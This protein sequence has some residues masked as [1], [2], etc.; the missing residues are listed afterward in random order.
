[1]NK[2][3]KQ[4]A[5][6]FEITGKD[7]E[8]YDKVSPIFGG[9]KYQIPPPTLCPSCRIQ[10]RHAWRNE[11]NLNKRKCDLCNR[12]IVSIYEADAAFPVF[13]NDC[14]WS[15]K[16]DA[17]EYGIDFEY[18]K[19]FFDQFKELQMKVPK[20]AILNNTVENSE[21]TNHSSNLKN[22]YLVTTAVYSEN[23]YHSRWLLKC[24]DVCDCYQ[25][26]HC[27]LCYE[28][29]YTDGGYNN[30]HAIFSDSQDCKFTYDCKG[31]SNCFMCSNLRQKK[32]CINNKQY[33]K[34]EY[35]KKMSTI[36]LGSYKEFTKYKSQY[37]DMIADTAIRQNVKISMSENSDYELIY[38]CKNVHNS[39]G[40][41][42][43][44][45]CSYCHENINSK[46]CY[47]VCE[48]ANCELHYETNGCDFSNN[49]MVCNRSDN[50]SDSLYLDSCYSGSNLFGCIGLKREKYCILNKQYSQ[51][52]YQKVAAKIA[53]HMSSTGEWG[54]FFP[55]ALS[56][57]AYNV[58][59]VNEDFPQ[60]KEEILSRGLRWKEDE[61]RDYQEQTYKIPDDIKDVPNSIM[62]EIL[63]CIDCSKNYKIVPSELELYK[64][65]NI[66][67]PRKCP[68]CRRKD[69][70]KLRA[71]LFQ[72]TQTHCAKC[73][74]KTNT[75]DSK[76]LPKT[77]YCEKCYLKE[78][79]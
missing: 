67:V 33:T 22:C 18:S 47:D 75:T 53:E 4:C 54:E 3:C 41:V 15:D 35:E 17:K 46:D 19:S 49:I 8:F 24:K 16:W 28:T 20:M 66:P 32:Y 56:P 37:Y 23:A 45:D 27:E 5:H 44:E 52:E 63:A 39:F 77:I 60:T 48:S 64:K 55:L 12:E 43:S 25:L 42:D 74:Q 30:V 31:C 51:E 6:P 70:K 76:Y 57:F 71:P 7:L 9:G 26:V 61:K 58:S 11:Y 40:T 38:K 21:Y 10:R 13:C 78:M 14:W 73:G 62:H 1:M 72:I 36:N 68:A 2:I 79:Y 65:L 59:I 29:L 69:R 50:M 34:E